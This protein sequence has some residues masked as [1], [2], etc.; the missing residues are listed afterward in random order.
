MHARRSVQSSP[1][2]VAKATVLLNKQLRFAYHLFNK[3]VQ[4]D[5]DGWTDS[6]GPAT[7]V[8]TT[9]LQRY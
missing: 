6:S 1:A 8:A 2:V 4:N 3:L 7:Y 5:Q 9:P